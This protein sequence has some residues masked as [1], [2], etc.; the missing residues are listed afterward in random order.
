MKRRKKW[1]IYENREDILEGKNKP[2]N[3][4]SERYKI[5]KNMKERKR[6]QI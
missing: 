6:D 1:K 4:K 3:M 5:W 2:E